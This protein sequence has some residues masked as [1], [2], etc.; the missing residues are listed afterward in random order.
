[1]SD[2]CCENAC[3]SETA[4]ADPRWRRVLGVALIVNAAMFL[5]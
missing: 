5:V 1:M 2:N 3:G 4:K